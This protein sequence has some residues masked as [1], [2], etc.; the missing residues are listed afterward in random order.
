[1]INAFI[2]NVKRRECKSVC[3]ISAL[4]LKFLPIKRGY[5]I[6]GEDH[7]DEVKLM[8]NDIFLILKIVFMAISFMGLCGA[9][10]NRFD[11]AG[12]IAPF[13][14][15]CGVIIALM[16]GGMA[17]ILPWVW[18]AL[19]A[20]GFAGFGYYYIYKRKRIEWMPVIVLGAALV[21]GLWRFNGVYFADSDTVSHWGLVGKY[22]LTFN[23][24]PNAST[25]LIFFQSYPLGT[26]CFV[27]YFSKGIGSMAPGYAL[28]AQFMLNVIAFLPIL[29]MARKNKIANYALSLATFA[30]VISYNISLNSLRVDTVY[31]VVALGATTGMLYYSRNEKRRNIIGAMGAICLIFIKNSGAF[32]GIILMLL[33]VYMAFTKDPERSKRTIFRTGTVFILA[34]LA[35][36]A[37]WN[38]HVKAVYDEG[39]S[40]MHAV[41]VSTYKDRLAEKLHTGLIGQIGKDMLW[42]ILTPDK[43]YA[44]LLITGIVLA[45]VCAMTARKRTETGK[46][47]ETI[48]FKTF[49]VCAALYVVWYVMLYFLYVFSMNA[50]EAKDLVSIGRYE[51]TIQIYIM[52]VVLLFIVNC[53]GDE[54]LEKSDRPVA[55]S[56]IAMG[57]VGL[58]GTTLIGR[59]S[60]AENILSRRKVVSAHEC[61]LTL[62][63]KYSIED[64]KSYMIFSR[65][66][67]RALY[68][69]Y[70]LIKYEFMSNDIFMI[71]GG[72]DMNGIDPE[73]YYTFQNTR[74]NYTEYAEIENMEDVLDEYIEDYDYVLVL[75]EDM[76]FN[77]ELD[78]FLE[79]YDGDTQILY[80]Y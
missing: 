20:G 40:T 4:K 10:K 69:A 63:N 29:S 78:R 7:N 52:G 56:I 31:P 50:W 76:T 58:I 47:W 44:C 72:S 43:E 73:K 75:D 51:K 79:S 34:M 8:R 17:Y 11:I 37:L 74:S 48:L 12:T 66:E 61:V 42:R 45:I 27:Y 25:D 65:G 16:L 71:I 2:R 67:K 15:A 68:N 53:F 38:I 9:V 57:I 39:L 49:G 80:A 32:F 3:P 55:W 46:K 54:S 35:A 30:F 24:F 19:F 33:A 77:E 14:S 59:V 6:I 28:C 70:Y 21:Y 13:V 36:F 41:S 62:R 64:G 23:K 26:A 1:M 22:M 5:A 18:A 60:V